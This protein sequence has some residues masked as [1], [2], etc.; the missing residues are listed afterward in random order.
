LIQANRKCYRFAAIGCVRFLFC[1]RAER[2][3]NNR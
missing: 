2:L 3:L 1:G